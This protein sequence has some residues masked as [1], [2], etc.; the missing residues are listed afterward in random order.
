MFD[1]ACVCVIAT[2]VACRGWLDGINE[3]SL[4]VGPPNGLWTKM[5]LALLLRVLYKTEMN[6]IPFFFSNVKNLVP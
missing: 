3:V 4:N 1:I 6:E 5:D 2:W